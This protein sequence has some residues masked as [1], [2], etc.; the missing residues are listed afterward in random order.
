MALT[1]DSNIPVSLIAY[2]IESVYPRLDINQWTLLS[3]LRKESTA[4]RRIEVPLQ[5]GG[6]ASNIRA[7]GTEV[8]AQDSS[9]TTVGTLNLGEFLIDHTMT[10]RVDQ[11]TEAVNHGKLAVNDLFQ[12]KTEEAILSIFRRLG[13]LV[14]TG[15]GTSGSAGIFGLNNIIDS[16]IYAGINSATH[17]KWLGSTFANGNTPRKL[18]RAILQN[19]EVAVANKEGSTTAIITT[20]AVE[21][22]LKSI[23]QNLGIYQLGE[24]NAGNLG[25]KRITYQGLDVYTDINCPAGSMYLVNL[26]TLGMKFYDV[27]I[28]ANS[29]VRE[30]Y[31]SVVVGGVPFVISDVSNP[32]FPEVFRYNISTSPQMWTAYRNSQAVIRD[33]STDL[34]TYNVEPAPP[35]P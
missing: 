8:S 18:N 13:G 15:D 16:A 10:I 26:P 12:I 27:R 19:A 35:E 11:F 21:E 23:Y 30:R 5:I 33:L 24:G 3:L 28:G 9:S 6:A 22:T 20:K 31:Q 2:Q 25:L 1:Y 7:Y 17:T 32:A 14:Y 29:Y 4:Q 34:S